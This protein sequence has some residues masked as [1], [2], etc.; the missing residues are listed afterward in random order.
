MSW[1]ISLALAACTFAQAPGEV[2]PETKLDI[3]LDPVRYLGRALAAWD[4]SAGFGRIQNQ[5]VGYLFPMGP[6]FAIGE[7]LGVPAWITQR[8]WVSLLLVLGYWG[9]HRLARAV[10]VGTASGRVVAGLA[11]TLSAASLATVAF[12]SAGQLPYVLAPWV[13][14]PLVTAG[15]GPQPAAGPPPARPWRSSPWAA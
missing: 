2:I 10:G 8:A 1:A 6:F 5:S 12:Q 15:T 13:L 3:T 9:A 4:P 7:A 14:V 11:Y